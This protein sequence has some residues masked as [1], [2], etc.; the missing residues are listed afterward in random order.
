M[1][2][3]EPFRPWPAREPAGGDPHLPSRA[4]GVPP[5]LFGVPLPVVPKPADG[6]IAS[7][8]VSG[9]AW[10]KVNA[11]VN[12]GGSISIPLL[13]A[14]GISFLCPAFPPMMCARRTH[15]ANN[16]IENFVLDPG[17]AGFTSALDGKNWYDVFMKPT[18][19]VDRQTM[20]FAGL[21]RGNSPVPHWVLE[22]SW[23]Y[24]DSTGDVAPLSTC[25]FDVNL[26][27]AR[28]FSPDAA[29]PNTPTPGMGSFYSSPD[30]QSVYKIWDLWRGEQGGSALDLA[31]FNN[32]ISGREA[33]DATGSSATLWLTDDGTSSGNTIFDPHYRPMVRV[34]GD[35][36]HDG[37]GGG[38]LRAGGAQSTWR[39]AS[40]GQGFWLPFLSD[41]YLLAGNG[42]IQ[43]TGSPVTYGLP[44][45]PKQYFNFS[46]LDFDASVGAY[47]VRW[48]PG[49]GRSSS[50]NDQTIYFF[51]LGRRDAGIS[52]PVSGS[53]RLEDYW[54]DA[55]GTVTASE[56]G[57]RTLYMAAIDISANIVEVWWTKDGT[58][59]GESIFNDSG[60]L[61]WFEVVASDES[62]ERLF[63]QCHQWGQ[64][65]PPSVKASRGQYY[66]EHR[67]VSGKWRSRVSMNG[68]NAAHYSEGIERSR[69]MYL[70][71]LG[72]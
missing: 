27:G 22:L 44:E 48:F 34:W 18:S 56:L 32:R 64:M 55:A 30:G 46:S 61:P 9:L 16:P 37:F 54:S 17:Y 24:H 39:P 43:W 58:S 31:L 57:E 63:H 69:L 45:N 5:G 40:L 53:G 15:L 65:W 26:V 19:D 62:D 66:H 72:D 47:R 6:P 42:S 4:A 50:T 7:T 8:C 12:I 3:G 59:A 60:K 36:E 33:I 41:P 71:A 28:P 14:N 25:N 49:T 2:W 20:A 21:R 10:I 11:S 67:Q 23:G 70:Y 13:D 35:H 68:Q 1:K 38:S 52:G 29:A 51:A